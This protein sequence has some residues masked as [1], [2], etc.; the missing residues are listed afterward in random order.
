[1]P[2]VNLPDGKRVHFPD[3][4][5]P[6]EITAAIEGLDAPEPSAG[7]SFVRGLKDPIDAGA[8]ML[9][10]ALP[11]G[12]VQGVNE[13][14]QFVNDLPYIGPLTKRLGMV[15]A[16]TEDID[17]D[18][19]VAEANYQARRGDDGVDWPRLGG[20]I[21]GTVPLFMSAPATLP[22]GV[23][24]GAG[25]GMLQP[26]TEGEFAEQKTKQALT[27]M[28]GGAAGNLIGRGVSRVVAPKVTEGVKA[29]MARGVTPT[30]GQVAGG[31]G[32]ALEEK[33][34]SI[35]LLGD[36]VKSGQRRA[37]QQFNTAV[38]DD[39][40]KPLG[41]K[42]PAGVG[43]DAVK[44]V[45]NKISAAYDDVLSKATFQVDRQF[46]DDVINL[47]GMVK[48][49]PKQQ[50]RDFARLVQGKIAK[51]L[52]PNGRIDGRTF[53]ELEEAVGDEAAKYAASGDVYQRK[54]GDAYK[55]LLDSLRDGLERSSGGALGKRL[56][57][58]NT[59]FAKLVRLDK[60]AGMQGAAE[61]V[62]TPAQLSSAVKAADRSSRKRA[63]ARGDALLQEISDPAKNV[64]GNVYPDSGTAGRLAAML[65]AGGGD[66]R[67]ITFCFDYILQVKR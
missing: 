33:L 6:D 43:R 9:T 3:G 16:T 37:I 7:E 26:V 11:E 14:T 10:H 56:K 67:M 34:T 49:L 5:S 39:I 50:A 40:L 57:E 61:G 18:I 1:V 45:G 21:A 46:M 65:A 19:R 66:S 47:N 44:E 60:A 12:V 27:G 30:P 15:P 31:A 17:K 52:A 38:Y 25:A 20:N 36:V 8:Q 29:L 59:A 22:G 28:A 62:F 24:A 23:V 48:E 13:A 32:K 2:V 63:F 4:M 41:E 42:I 55:A 51:A 35:P 53:K 58:V 54:L 64:I